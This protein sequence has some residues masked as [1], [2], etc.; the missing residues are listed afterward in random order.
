M[1]VEKLEYISDYKI[2]LLFSDNKIKVVDLKQMIE[3]AKGIFLPLKDVNYFKKVML[4]DCELS[5]CWPNGADICPDVLYEIGKEIKQ[6]VKP[7]VRPQR[8]SR[9]RRQFAKS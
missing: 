8:K 1:R 5:I 2:R 9:S 6:T 3:N 4:D 7:S